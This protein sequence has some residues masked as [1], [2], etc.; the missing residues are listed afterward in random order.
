MP[1][2]PVMPIGRYDMRDKGMTNGDSI[3]KKRWIFSTF[4]VE[5]YKFISSLI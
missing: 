1:I 5:I 4:F 2:V 3:A